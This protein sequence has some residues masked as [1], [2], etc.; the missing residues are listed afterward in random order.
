MAIVNNEN[1]DSIIIFAK[2]C[3]FIFLP[4]TKKPLK[5]V[6]PL[7]SGFVCA[8]HAAAPGSNLKHTIYAFMKRRK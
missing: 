3:R 4:I 2:V 1:L 8:F 5:G 6:P 7:L